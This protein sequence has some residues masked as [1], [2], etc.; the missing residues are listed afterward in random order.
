MATG[1][2]QAM[3]RR[4]V[5]GSRVHGADEC[6]R[7]GFVVARFDQPARLAGPDDLGMPPTADATT[8]RP[9]AAASMATFSGFSIHGDCDDVDGSVQHRHLA[10]R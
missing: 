1:T 5:A 6:R 7:H 9:A 3:R 4:A 2:P 10:S 8:G